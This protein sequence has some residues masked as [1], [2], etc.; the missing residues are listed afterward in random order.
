VPDGG[1]AA[2][3]AVE[4]TQRQDVQAI[5]QL[6]Q[7]RSELQRSAV[8]HVNIEVVEG[9]PGPAI[10]DTARRR[11]CD[12]I[13]MSTHGRSGVGRALLGSVADYVVRHSPIPVLLVRADSSD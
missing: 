9:V 12:L 11:G 2:E 5:Q 10:V 4:E 1:A 3:V 8:M 13:M 7:L 6:E